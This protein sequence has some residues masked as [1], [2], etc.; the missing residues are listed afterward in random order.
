MLHCSPG[1][2]LDSFR[3]VLADRRAAVKVSVAT[4]NVRFFW[5]G[6]IN[7]RAGWTAATRTERGH[8]QLFN[9]E[10]WSWRAALL[11]ITLPGRATGAS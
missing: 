2:A 9:V 4:V 5:N 10:T 1:V 11:P 8:I 7:I 3:T 6:S